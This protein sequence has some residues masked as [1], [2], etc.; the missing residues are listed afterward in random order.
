MRGMWLDWVREREW[1]PVQTCK[2]RKKYKKKD[3]WETSPYFY[4]TQD[5]ADA[6]EPTTLPDDTQAKAKVAKPVVTC[7]TFRNVWVREFPNLKVHAW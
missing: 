4:K 6:V 3:C 7:S 2:S 5:Q 1:D